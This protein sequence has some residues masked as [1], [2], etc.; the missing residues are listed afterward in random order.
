MIITFANFKGGVGKTTTTALFSYLLA[1]KGY[2]VL[3]V[4]LDPQGNL[5]KTLARTYQKEL[6]STKNIFNSLFSEEAT[7]SDIQ[8]LSNNLDIITG[9]WDMVYFEREADKKYYRKD[10]HRLLNAMLSEVN[11]V[12]DFILLDTP[13]TTGVLMDN[14]I[15]ATNYV[16]IVTQTDEMDYDSTKN[17]Y[18]YL[19]DRSQEESHN[20]EL[21]GVLPYLV[22]NSATDR[23]VFEEYKKVFE[24]ELFSNYIRSSDRV[25]TWNRK[26]IT[27]NQG[28]DKVTLSMYDDIVE[29]ALE[30]LGVKNEK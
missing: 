11:D 9:S 30:R 29:E 1:K 2:K 5:T 19:V 28:H 24:V 8:S 15:S 25:K 6:L 17:F 18:E 22:G 27:E 10:H 7:I 4:D 23:A 20:F 16:V 14:A 26:G 13:P 21:L 3:T 12:Y